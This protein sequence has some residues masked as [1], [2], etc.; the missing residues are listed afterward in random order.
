M[1]E[2]PSG[3]RLG[4]FTSPP[5]ECGYLPARE[6][7]TMF[8]DPRVPLSRDTYTW[9]S[10]HGFRRSGTHVYRPHCGA[11]NACIAVRVAV[12]EFVPRRAH[13][14]TLADNA[15]VEIVRRPARFEREHF[16]LYE[17]YLAA[18]H[19]DSQMD[20]TNAG[21]Y[22]SFLTAPWCETEFWE[23]REA[24][25]LLAVAVVD[26]LGDG[27][28]SVYTF[29]SPRHAGRSLGRFAILK[30]IESARASGL[31]WLYLG[32]WIRECRK[33]V[34]KREY[35][36]LEYFR[37]GHWTRAIP[38]GGLPDRPGPRQG[39]TLPPPAD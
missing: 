25:E 33:M 18:R 11:C 35:A 19:P 4:F 30:Q 26:R 20:A 24:D 21:A 2:P 29:F 12:A 22:M 38:G 15:A 31:P 34:Y 6:A 9:L 36:P 28:S 27:L 39:E 3:P 32:Y 14:R 1:T 16:R 37:G 17:S 8:A 23:F 5:H 7:V 13:R 10:A